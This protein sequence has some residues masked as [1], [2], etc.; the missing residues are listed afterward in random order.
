MIQI[1]EIFY[2]LQGKDLFVQKNHSHNEIEFIQVINGNGFVV[3]NDKTYLLQSHHV[4]VI[5]AR[6]THIVYPESKEIDEYIR[7]KIV[8]DAT[9]FERFFGDIGL[10]EIL[11]S[12]YD[13]APISTANKPEIDGVFK[14]YLKTDEIGYFIPGDDSGVR[15]AVPGVFVAGDVADPHYRQAITAAAS[16]CKAALE[17]ERYLSSK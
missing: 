9:S 15:T 1:N 10:G 16:G 11:D 3:K 6:N 5:D 14:K 4:Y 17:A 13:S 12:L 2:H 7:N 8:I